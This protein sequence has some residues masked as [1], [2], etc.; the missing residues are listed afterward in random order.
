[1]NPERAIELCTRKLAQLLYDHRRNCGEEGTPE[2]DW[3]A[4]EA[5]LRG[6]S[7]VMASVLFSTWPDSFTDLNFEHTYGEL[8]YAHAFQYLVAGR[9]PA[10]DDERRLNRRVEIADYLRECMPAFMGVEVATA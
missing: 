4:A 1:M 2:G 10:T 8:I 6:H 5:W 7:E 3:H 9:D